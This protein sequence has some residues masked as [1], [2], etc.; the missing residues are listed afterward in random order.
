MYQHWEGTPSYVF[1]YDHICYTLTDNYDHSRNV[2]PFRLADDGKNSDDA[3]IK[4]ELKNLWWSRYQLTC[5][6]FRIKAFNRLQFTSQLNGAKKHA[7]KSADPVFLV[8]TF[9]CATGFGQ[10]KK[11]HS[12]QGFL[13]GKFCERVATRMLTDK[14]MNSRLRLSFFHLPLGAVLFSKLLLCNSFESVEARA[15]GRW[16]F[17][18]LNKK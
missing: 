2:T 17:S 12:S 13:D 15:F 5:N 1:D 4:T 9:V 18:R 3:S 11:L 8:F 7:E 16:Y 10:K 6:N 14:Q